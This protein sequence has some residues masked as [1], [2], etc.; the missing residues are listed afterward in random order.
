[1]INDWLTL[2]V[3]NL[4]DYDGFMMMLYSCVCVCVFVF[5]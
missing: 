1:M 5:V 2:I 3:T 4:I